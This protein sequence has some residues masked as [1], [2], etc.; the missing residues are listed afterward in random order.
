VLIA[1][2]LQ[3]WM[4]ERALLLRYIVYC[5]V[6]CCRRFAAAVRTPAR[7]D[8]Q[9]TRQKAS[10]QPPATSRSYTNTNTKTTLR[11]HQMSIDNRGNYSHQNH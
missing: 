9:R 6:N 4:Q 10:A 5:E 8:A 2:P 11:D 1:F 3:K 7:E